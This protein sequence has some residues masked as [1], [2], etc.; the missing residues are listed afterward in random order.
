MGGFS[1]DGTR[2][3]GVCFTAATAVG[4]ANCSKAIVVKGSKLGWFVIGIQE[5][6]FQ[7]NRFLGNLPHHLEV[8]T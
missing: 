1:W 2:I 7:V 4:A 6:K 8:Q 3:V 5:L